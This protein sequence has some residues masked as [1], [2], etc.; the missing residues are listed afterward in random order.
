MREHDDYAA[1][2]EMIKL[3]NPDR[4]EQ[5]GLCQRCWRL[6]IG[7]CRVGDFFEKPEC[8]TKGR[9]WRPEQQL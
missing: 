5:N 1:T 7:L 8:A 9:E 3:L 2:V 4:A 6:Y